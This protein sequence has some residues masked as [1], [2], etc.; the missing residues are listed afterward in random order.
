MTVGGGGDVRRSILDFNPLNV[1][2]LPLVYTQIKP[3]SVGVVSVLISLGGTRA[4]CC[5]ALSPPNQV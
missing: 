1:W 3:S 2:A 5:A 4:R